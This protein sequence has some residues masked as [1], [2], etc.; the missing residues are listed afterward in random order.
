VG[1]DSSGRGGTADGGLPWGGEELTRASLPSA[2][3]HDGMEF[4]TQNDA[5]ALDVLTRRKCW[6]GRGE[7][8]AWHQLLHELGRW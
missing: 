5:S 4:P 2:L 6:L 1:S 3:G 7:E 8:G